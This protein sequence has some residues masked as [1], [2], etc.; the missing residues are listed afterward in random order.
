[1]GT[2]KIASRGGQNHKPTRADIMAQFQQHFGY[3]ITL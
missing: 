1:M 3:A 2:I